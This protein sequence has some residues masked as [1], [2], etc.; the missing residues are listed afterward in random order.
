MELWDS[1]KSEVN[2]TCSAPLGIGE[3]ARALLDI[4]HNAV[5]W[6]GWIINGRPQEV[7]IH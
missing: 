3:A 7:W 1:P 4:T 2:R 5:V 6:Q